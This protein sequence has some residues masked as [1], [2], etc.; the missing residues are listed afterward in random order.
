MPGSAVGY[1][2]TITNTGQT[3]YTAITVTDTVDGLENATYNN[4]AAATA[5]TVSY[6]A[7]R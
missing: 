5:G 6:T 1:T 4:D 7:P 2:L 3:P